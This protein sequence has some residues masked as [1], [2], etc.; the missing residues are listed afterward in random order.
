[1]F[2]IVSVGHQKALCVIPV[3]LVKI[4]D[5]RGMLPDLIQRLSHMVKGR[6]TQFDYTIM[7]SKI[8]IPQSITPHGDFTGS[9]GVA[10]T[11]HAAVRYAQFIAQDHISFRVVENLM[12]ILNLY[13][14]D[15]DQKVSADR[16]QDTNRIPLPGI[17]VIYI[18]ELARLERLKERALMG[19]STPYIQW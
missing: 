14:Y 12:T 18:H 10:E 19:I 4:D 13:Q 17:D 11:I 9:V 1:M 5:L 15:L 16:R 3:S 7:G 8:D 6:V 2:V